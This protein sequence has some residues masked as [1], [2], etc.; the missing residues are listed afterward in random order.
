MPTVSLRLTE[1]EH[2]RLQEWAFGSRRSLQREI[3]F[4]LFDGAL[5]ERAVQPRNMTGDV[6]LSVPPVSVS[7]S[8]QPSAHDVPVERVAAPRS[9]SLPSGKAGAPLRDGKCSADVARGTKCKL[10]GKVH[11]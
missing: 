8:V 4:R 7:A 11:S 2:S 10:C 5:T 3:V 6:H 9:W 1:D